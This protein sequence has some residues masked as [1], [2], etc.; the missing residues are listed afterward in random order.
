MFDS[1][2]VKTIKMQDKMNSLLNDEKDLTQKTADEIAGET[3]W[4]PVPFLL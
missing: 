4:L 3:R 1:S 2:V